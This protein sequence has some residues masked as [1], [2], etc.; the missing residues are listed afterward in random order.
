[1][2]NEMIK[3]AKECKSADELLALAKENGIE[4]TAEEANEKFSLLHN[5]CELSDDELDSASGG[6]CGYTSVS[7][8]GNYYKKIDDRTDS[9]NKFVCRECGGGRAGHAAGCTI[10]E[11]LGDVC[12]C[13][14][15]SGGHQLTG[16]YCKID[17][18]TNGR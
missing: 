10:T 7:I 14:I 1:M 6:A 2:T 11:G 13:C 12:L 15:H 17:Y 18:K 9:C 4:M 3:N 5:D 8:D 16:S